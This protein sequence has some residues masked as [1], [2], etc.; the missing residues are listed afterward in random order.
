MRRRSHLIAQRKMR[1]IRDQTLAVVSTAIV[2]GIALA[3]IV[4]A[5]V[6]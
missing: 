5:L 6:R 1:R 3:I 4:P 2:A